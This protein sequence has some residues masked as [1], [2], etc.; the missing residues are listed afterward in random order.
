VIDCRGLI[1]SKLGVQI[2]FV[3]FFR[4]YIFIMYRA[5][6]AIFAYVRLIFMF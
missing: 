1:S 3:I 2:D 6:E 4:D 5:L